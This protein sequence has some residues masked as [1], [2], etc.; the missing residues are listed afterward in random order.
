MK[1]HSENRTTISDICRI[2]LLFCGP[3]L[4]ASEIWKQWYLT[5][6][7]N[8]GHYNPWYFPFQLCSIPM[9]ILLILHPTKKPS[10]RGVLLVFLMCC[11]TLGGIA[12]FADT[13]GL[14]Y[15]VAALT[16]HSYLWHILLIFIGIAAGI[17]YR[18]T[19]FC[20]F[21]KNPAY[22]GSTSSPG[23]QPCPDLFFVR[24]RHDFTGSIILYLICCGIASVLNT[25]FDPYGTIN[26]FYINPRYPMIQ[27]VFSELVKYIGNIPTIFLYMASTILGSFLI[28]R[29]WNYIFKIGG[30]T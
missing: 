26:M 4:A 22:D 2:F 21:S 20:N 23:C 18:Q 10:V 1:M 7:I 3:V 15:P 12:V 14:H 29:I 17:Y 9:Y 24:F 6:V 27:V 8:Q 25:C 11:G 13:S 28:F 30:R 5:F 16:V 19:F